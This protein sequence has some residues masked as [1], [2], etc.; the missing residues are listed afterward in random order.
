LELVAP[1]EIQKAV[2]LVVSESYGMPAAEVPTAV[3]R[4][5]G[6]A[7]TTDDMCTLVEHNCGE[8]LSRGELRASG[9]NL[10]IPG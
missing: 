5:L 1:E 2:R 7:H 8:L 6:F 10:A 3:C 4:F 9:I